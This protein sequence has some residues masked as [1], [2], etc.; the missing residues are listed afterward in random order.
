MTTITNILNAAK[1]LNAN[2]FA[3]FLD[4]NKIAYTILD[5]NIMD[6]NDDYFNII[7]DKFDENILFFNGKF[8]A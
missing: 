2:N 5:C 8:Q 7:I 1:S 4:N 3:S 6:Y